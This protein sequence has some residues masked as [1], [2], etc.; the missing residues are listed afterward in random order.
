M[1]LLVFL[2]R[3]S[4]KQSYKDS[5]S[6]LNSQ[7]GKSAAH[8][9]ALGLALLLAILQA[10]HISEFFSRNLGPNI[11]AAIGVASGHP[12]WRVYQSRILGPYLVEEMAKFSN[13]YLAAYV[14]LTTASLALAGY[15]AWSIGRKAGGDQVGWFAL[16]LLHLAFTF[17]L[18]HPWLYI[19]DFIGLNIFLAMAD[20][21]M[22]ERPLHWFVFLFVIAI[23]NRES[24]QVI[25]L[26]MILHPVCR[27]LVGYP[28]S[29][30]AAMRMAVA[31]SLCVIAGMWVVE[32]L[33]TSLLIRE[34]GFDIVGG[35]PLGYGKDFWWNLPNNLA[36]LNK[37]MGSSFVYLMS[38]SLPL[39][40]F[41]AVVAFA[42]VLIRRDA[43]RY[44]A[45]GVTYM[46]SALSIFLFGIV[47]ETRVFVEI[48]P[49]VILG[50]CLLF[51]SRDITPKQTVNGSD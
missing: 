15:Q 36:V 2:W 48:I 5:A 14:L 35:T 9:H 7:S 3:F 51:P 6:T 25:A 32:F 37:L 28:L 40:M 29:K 43:Q 24:G 17:L 39:I 34:V 13:D 23:L 41:L 4:L 26:W 42:V 16:I 31:G 11:E 45:L 49:L 50:S 19:W 27:W 10:H 12:H 1:Y 44:L 46:I 47:S 8:Y 18:A 33:R 30:H 22:S 38:H 21:V 20:F